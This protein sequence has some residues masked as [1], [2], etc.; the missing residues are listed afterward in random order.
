MVG[1]AYHRHFKLRML[2]AISSCIKILYEIFITYI[3]IVAYIQ[4]KND[5]SLQPKYW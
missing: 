2:K 3:N 4:I 5:E 1:K